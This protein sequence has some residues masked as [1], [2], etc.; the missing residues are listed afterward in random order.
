MQSN[1]NKIQYF[2]SQVLHP[3]QTSNASTDKTLSEIIK[4][5]EVI[6]F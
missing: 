3:Q 1:L 5:C 6:F 4:G 2:S